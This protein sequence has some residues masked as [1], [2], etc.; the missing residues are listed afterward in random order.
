MPSDVQARRW[1]GG[2]SES[3]G[4]EDSG[5]EEVAAQPRGKR[6]R[7]PEDG[8]TSSEDEQ[9]SEQESESEVRCSAGMDLGLQ[10]PLAWACA[11]QA[12]AGSGWEGRRD[13]R[14]GLLSARSGSR[15]QHRGP[16]EALQFHLLS[17]PPP[18]PCSLTRRAGPRIS[19]W[20]NGVRCWRTA[21]RAGRP[22]LP[23]L[24]P[25]GEAPAPASA[26]AGTSPRR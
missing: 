20:A 23:G 6:P 14:P 12:G 22:C 17:N 8:V 1:Q 24:V 15:L 11:G 18:G 7:E 26:P 10:L 5:P 3:S 2:A 16:P 25:R 19:P 13:Q 9:D 4:D 21:P